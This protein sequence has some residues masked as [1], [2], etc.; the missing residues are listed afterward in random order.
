[1]TKV[2]DYFKEK[3]DKNGPA[4]LPGVLRT[5]D[6]MPP[7]DEVEHDESPWGEGVVEK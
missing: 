4:F 3:Y 6:K 5:I 7:E 2:R 1:L